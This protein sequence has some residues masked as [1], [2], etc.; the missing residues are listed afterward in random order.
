[1]VQIRILSSVYFSDAD[2]GACLDTRK[3]TTGFFEFLGKSMVSWRSKKQ[4]TISRSA[5]SEYRSMAAAT[6][7]ALWVLCLLKDLGI[8]CHKPVALFCDSQAAIHIVSNPV[9]HERTKHIG[10]IVMSY[11]KEFRLESSSYACSFDSPACRFVYKSTT[12]ISVSK[13]FVQDGS[14]QH[15]LLILRESFRNLLT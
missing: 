5:E 9:F 7:E 14:T 11:K 6:C 13:S 8:Q 3:S 10:S 1:M 4:Q 12:A 2:W 15:P